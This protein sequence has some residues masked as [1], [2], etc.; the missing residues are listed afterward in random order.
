MGS[1]HEA[2]AGHGKYLAAMAKEEQ[3]QREV[4]FHEHLP[5]MFP[6]VHYCY[7]T[8]VERMLE[9]EIVELKPIKEEEE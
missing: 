9:T 8:H 7:K 5:T 1:L 6:G 3:I 4:F 2:R